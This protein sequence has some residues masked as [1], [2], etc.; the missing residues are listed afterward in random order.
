MTLHHVLTYSEGAASPEAPQRSQLRSRLRLRLSRALSTLRPVRADAS[1]SPTIPS[2]PG[3]SQDDPG[4]LAPVGTLPIPNEAAASTREGGPVRNGPEA[5]PTIPLAMEQP[6]G[7]LLAAASHDLRQPLQAIGLWI[8]IL[9][10]EASDE[11]MSGVLAKI[12]ETAHNLEAVLDSLLD[13]SRLDMCRVEAHPA[14]FPVSAL[15]DRIVA[16]FAPAAQ[17]KGLQLRIRPSAASIHS[18]RLLLDRIVGNLVANAI[19]YTSHG[20]VLVGC[21]ERAGTLSI[22]VWDTGSGIPQERLGDI[23]EEFVQLERATQGRDR[24]AGL[25]LAIAKRI[26]HLLGQEIH[27]ASHVGRGSCFRVEVPLAPSLSLMGS[28]ASTCGSAATADVRGAFVAFIDDEPAVR[29]AMRDTLERWG[30][31]VVVA[32]SASKALRQL[33]AHLRLP[34]VLIS[35]YRLVQPET[36]LEAIRTIRAALGSKIPAAIISGERCAGIAKASADDGIV[37]LPK[38]IQSRDLRSLIASGYAA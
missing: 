20:G 10:T 7:S 33:S 13:I 12:S 23:F 37:V 21:R 24:G 8:E 31:H 11:R 15:L 29:D 4:R 5:P 14:D 36:G 2:S 19:R 34:D 18:D 35:D 28:S 9:R 30:C 38:P 32:D 6:E 22:E 26:A 17:S 3:A 25:G 16:T 1:A 27:V